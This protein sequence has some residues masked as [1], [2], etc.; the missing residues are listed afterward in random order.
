M[1]ALNEASGITDR[2]H[3]ETSPTKI[4]SPSDSAK[5]KHLPTL[6]KVVFKAEFWRTWFGAISP[7]KTRLP[8]PPPPRAYLGAHYGTMP[9]NLL[10]LW[11][12]LLWWNTIRSCFL[13]WDR[14][15]R[16]LVSQAR[17]MLLKTR[18]KTHRCH[19]GEADDLCFF[20][21]KHCHLSSLIHWTET[22]LSRVRI[23]NIRHLKF[24]CRIKWARP[25][26][27]MHTDA[28]I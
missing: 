23:P 20:K 15:V 7:R 4:H 6:G 10:M 24:S 12:D 1:S 21:N 11:S 17:L 18:S 25:L 3:I 19:L 5:S 13:W 22:S 14:E 9:F 2:E 16:V 8:T 27:L 28:K 26:Y